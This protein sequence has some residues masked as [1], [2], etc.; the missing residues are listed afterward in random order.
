MH[1]LLLGIRGEPGVGCTLFG[2]RNKK[3]EGAGERGASEVV[4][5]R[6]AGCSGA[7]GNRGRTNLPIIGLLEVGFPPQDAFLGA[8]CPPL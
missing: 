4:V 3:D 7:A 6:R 1:G 5:E 2:R 8:V